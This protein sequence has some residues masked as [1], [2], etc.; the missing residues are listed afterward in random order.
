MSDQKQELTDALE[1]LV[2]AVPRNANKHRELV[3]WYEKW[4]NEK[5]RGS[6]V[7]E[8]KQAYNR[9][10]EQFK[11]HDA[12]VLFVYSDPDVPR[13]LISTMLKN[14]YPALRT[15]ALVRHSG[16]AFTPEGI[17]TDGANPV[18]TFFT[19]N[20][21]KV[22]VE[23]LNKLSPPAVG[24]KFGEAFA[25]ACDTAHLRV[26][27]SLQIRFLA[28]VLAKRFLI[29]TGLSGCGK[30][31]LAKVFAEWIVDSP[32]RYVLLPV[33]ADW[34]SRENLFGFP[35]ALTPGQY[36]VPGN[37]V[38]ELMLRAEKDW[39]EGHRRP[40]VIV[41]DEMNLSHV[42]RYFADVL[43]AIESGGRIPLHEDR[44]IEGYDW[45]GI[46]ASTSVAP[47]LFIIGTVNVDETT[48]MFSPKVLDRANVLEFTA[49][50]TD[51]IDFIAH[52]Q[53]IDHGAVASAG[54]SFGEGIVEQANADASLSSL[55]EKKQS[56]SVEKRVSQT[57]A[58]AFAVLSKTGA[59]FG[60]RSAFEI[61]RLIASYATVVGPSWALDDALDAA[62]MQKL[63]PKLHG[64][65][66]KLGPVLEELKALITVE[67]FPI[68]ADK[69]ARME[70]R[71]K[72]NGFT[73]Y[74]EA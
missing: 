13:P 3:K 1:Y 23:A 57:L 63:L 68:S 36:C 27:K 33:G 10:V 18:S 66:T 15:V 52:P 69:I 48:Y 42:E 40:H 44:D 64:S 45:N 30:T 46:P 41:L 12:H 38:L 35:D 74:A 25:T 54:K 58:D 72:Q 67:R 60:Y 59:E 6:V 55:R 32:E 51:L 8:A 22:K 9:P 56:E 65:K 71:L 5:G 16:N 37:G 21:P 31:Q 7:S 17:W 47:N 28:S 34:T 50:C 2:N 24:S 49:S 14:V 53:A 4:F 26:P 61:V 62:I 29:L 11:H 20:Y 70:T 39:D 19:S 73:S 43:S